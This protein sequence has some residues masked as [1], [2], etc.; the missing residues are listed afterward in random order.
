MNNT[1]KVELLSVHVY[2]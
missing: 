1:D 2:I